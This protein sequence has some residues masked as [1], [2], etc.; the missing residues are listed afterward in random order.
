MKNSTRAIL[1]GLALCASLIPASHASASDDAVLVRWQMEASAA[2]EERALYEDA[3]NA[4]DE[5]RWDR[6]IRQFDR[7]ARMKGSRADG[8]LYWKAWAESRSGKRQDAIQTLASLEAAYPKSRWMKDAKALQLEIQ[9][10]SGSGVSLDNVEDE[11]LKLIALYGIIE[12]DPDRGV[13]AVRKILD[14][15]SSLTMKGRALYLLAESESPKANALLRDVAKGGN[16]DLQLAAVRLLGVSEDREAMAL[17]DEVYA[18][19]KERELRF[20]VIEAWREADA[21]PQLRRVAESEADLHMRVAAVIALGDTE[22][23]ATL[24]KIYD[25]APL[26]IRHAILGALESADD[27]KALEKIVRAEKDPALRMH[28]I[29]V[30][31]NASEGGATDTLVAMYDSETSA[32]AKH[33]IISSLADTDQAAAL[34]A[35]VKRE[36]NPEW[37]RVI[38]Q[39]LADMDSKEAQ[40]FLESLLD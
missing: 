7:V 40:A 31:A 24:T 18:T 8:A 1:S 16:P 26:E 13:A 33:A 2:D 21:L 36:K 5:R 38:V 15:S 27:V 22:D 3:T 11:E 32:E 35:I 9:Q 37:R 29:H 10:S 19:S 28:A 12:N 14:S 30:F 4:L 39:R 25:G 23:T 6:A 34:I 20:A 17:L